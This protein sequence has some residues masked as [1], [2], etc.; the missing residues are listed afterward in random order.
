MKIS[1]KDEEVIES[2]SRYRVFTRDEAKIDE[3]FDS[4]RA[5]GRMSAAEGVV[6]AG[7]PVF[8]V[9]QK[10]KGR[11]V[12]DLRGLNAKVI[13]DA[14]PLPRQDEIL[15]RLKGKQWISVFDLRKAFYQ[16]YIRHRDR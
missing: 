6:P 10:G 5:D 13:P 9:W 16:R 4:A 12:V 15:V 1:L 14:Y 8:V 11:P 7:W 3:I 2:K